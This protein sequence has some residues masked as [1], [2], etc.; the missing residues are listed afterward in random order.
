MELGCQRYV[1]RISQ[2]ELQVD[3]ASAHCLCGVENLGCYPREHGSTCAHPAA[4][5]V[6]RLVGGVP[7]EDA[8]ANVVEFTEQYG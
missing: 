7:A 4:D 3:V 2:V 8:A 5:V 6:D 1:H